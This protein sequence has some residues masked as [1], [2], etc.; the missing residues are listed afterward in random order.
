M[1]SQRLS[2]H[3]NRKSDSLFDEWQKKKTKRRET[4]MFTGALSPTDT[5]VLK[6]EKPIKERRKMYSK[7][8]EEFTS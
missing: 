6:M 1:F 4:T 8:Y 3:V 2:E 7:D 5:V